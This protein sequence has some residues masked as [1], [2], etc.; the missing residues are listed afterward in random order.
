MDIQ[1][2]FGYVIELLPGLVTAMQLTGMSLALGFPLAL[3]FALLI[4]I[5]PKPLNW[6]VIGAVEIGR[7][8]P[9]LV[10]L[11][12]FYQGLPQIDIVPSAMVA[13]VSAFTWSTASYATETIRSS[14]QS[15][16]RGQLEAASAAGLTG[17]D[18]FRFV[19]MPQ[20]ARIAIPPLMGLAIIMFQLSS[21]AYVITI[22]EV[23]QSAYFLGTKT[24]NYLPVFLAAAAVYASITIP[25]SALVTSIERRLAKHV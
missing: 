23:M 12:I 22:S 21:L 15:V 13:A 4:D 19:I 9:L 24:F 14:I 8:V 3:A 20:A 10:L 5:A 17:V 1:T 18:S 2:W 11:Y 7:G 16:P 6:I 25:A